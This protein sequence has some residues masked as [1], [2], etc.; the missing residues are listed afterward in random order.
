MNANNR[1]AT[2]IKTNE[3]NKIISTINFD[4]CRVT[5]KLQATT[6]IAEGQG[7]LLCPPGADAD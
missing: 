6:G 1:K 2:S 5:E 4:N 7:L 3:N